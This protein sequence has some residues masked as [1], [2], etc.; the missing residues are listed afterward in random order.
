MAW[1]LVSTALCYFIQ[2][3]QVKALFGADP[4]ALSLKG[5]AATHGRGLPTHCGTNSRTHQKVC[6][7]AHQ[8]HARFTTP[9]TSAMLRSTT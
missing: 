8:K 2:A 6:E 4:C 1:I 7:P 3:D 9:R 5:T